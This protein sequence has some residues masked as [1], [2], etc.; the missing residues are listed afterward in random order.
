MLWQPVWT[1]V[2]YFVLGAVVLAT[3]LILPDVRVAVPVP[4]SAAIDEQVIVEAS[5]AEELRLAA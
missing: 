3:R 1:I 5:A 4:V 2:G